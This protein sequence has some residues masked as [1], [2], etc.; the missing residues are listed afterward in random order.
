MENIA[1]FKSHHTR[2]C[3][4]EEIIAKVIEF[5]ANPQVV[6]IMGVLVEFAL[7]FAK[8]EEPKSILISIASVVKMVGNC[9]VK[10]SEFL[11]KV[12]GQKLK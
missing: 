2:K 9:L 4:M 1:I 10:M 12:I 8:T 7:R 11:D 3:N 5:I 6:L